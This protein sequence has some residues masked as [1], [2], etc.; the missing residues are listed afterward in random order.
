[1][2]ALRVL[3]VEDDA[4]LGMYLAEMLVGMG[5]DICAIEA[6]E[7]AAVAAASR[8]EPDLMI[9]DARLRDGSGIAA[10]EQILS[11]SQI[12]HLFVSGDTK[13]VQE[14]RPGAVVLRKPFR[15]SELASAI[16]RARDD[17]LMNLHG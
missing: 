17:N 15:E 14:A 1:M 10:V 2:T 5:Y 16:R 7:A 6:T 11:S 8:Y 13:S 3:V 4:L 9:V 12:P